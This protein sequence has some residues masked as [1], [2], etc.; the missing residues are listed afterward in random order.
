MRLYLNGVQEGGNVASTRALADN[1]TA[2]RIG[3]SAT[4]AGTSVGGTLDEAAI[5]TTVLT[6]A[7]I[8]AHYNAGRL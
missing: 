2:L 7:Q 4:G 8:Q 3:G 6:Q 5:Y 1:T